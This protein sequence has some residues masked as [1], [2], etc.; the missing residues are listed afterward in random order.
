[1][2]APTEVAEPTSPRSP[3]SPGQE[4]PLPQANLST[5]ILAENDSEP[6]EDFEDEDD[7][8]YGS[9]GL[10][11]YSASITSSIRNHV[12]ENGL[13]YHAFKQDSTYYPFPNDENEQNRD[14]IKH[15][16]TMMLCEGKLHYAPLGDNPQSI[17]D[18]VAD[19]YPGAAVEGVDLSAIQPNFVP[20]NLKFIID[21]IEEEWL[22]PE[23][24]IDYVHMRHTA[25]TIKNKPQ[26]LDCAIQAIKPGGYFEFQEILYYPSCDD[27][28]MTDPYPVK[29]W[30]DELN[31]GIANLGGDNF[32][33]SKL[34]SQMRDA[35]FVN[36]EE[37]V[38]KLPLGTWPKDK[39][40][41]RTGLYWR[42]NISDGLR[43]ICS[44]VFTRGLGWKMEAIDVYLIEVRKSLHDASKHV[45]FPLYIVVGQKPEAA[46]E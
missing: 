1:M 41:K 16:M 40:L 14:D 3:R 7:S 6:G 11:S 33:A 34:A 35:G 30:I 36:V 43:N 12:H 27:G 17:L 19:K 32:G 20:P 39:V 13:R 38:L 9:D 4:S 21:D 37:I 18:L 44:R 46:P 22:Y 24:S 28:T 15:A 45:Y 2:S 23:N 10:S 31:K 25:Q 5:T 8:A 29:D 26:L 42:V